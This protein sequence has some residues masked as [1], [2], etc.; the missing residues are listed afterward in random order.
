M[1]RFGIISC[2]VACGVWWPGMSGQWA[3]VSGVVTRNGCAPRA[4]GSADT[5]ARDF[6]RF[7]HFLDREILPRI[8]F[9]L[10]QKSRRS[11]EGRGRAK[12]VGPTDLGRMS[13]VEQ[14]RLFV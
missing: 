4:A 6:L 7:L 5:P 2:L 3:V 12:T 10:A 11:A 1:G 9:T 13:Q 8:T 14:R